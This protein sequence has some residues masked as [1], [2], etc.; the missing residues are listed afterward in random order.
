MAQN[1]V[2]DILSR[3]AALEVAAIYLP[4]PNYSDPPL[5]L[6]DSEGNHVGTDSI[7]RTADLVKGLPVFTG[8]PR[9]S[10]SLLD[11]VQSIINLYEITEQYP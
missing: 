10:N 3:I 1:Q 2:Q 9:E 5:Y 8:E 11:D 4:G 6:F 7:E